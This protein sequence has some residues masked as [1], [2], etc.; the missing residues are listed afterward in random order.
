MK[1]PVAGF[2]TALPVLLFIALLLYY[3]VAV[4]LLSFDHCF[5]ALKFASALSR[6]SV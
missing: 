5:T 3:I 2:D 1:L 6:P 4:M